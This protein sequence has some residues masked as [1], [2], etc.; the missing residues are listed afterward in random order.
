M[1]AIVFCFW[2]HLA[3]S[4]LRFLHFALIGMCGVVLGLLLLSCRYFAGL[5]FVFGSVQFVMNF[6]GC[7]C[8]RLPAEVGSS[9]WGVFVCSVL[10]LYCAVLPVASRFYGWPF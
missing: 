1:I 7:M 6:A 8:G 10:L 2:F 5:G 4:C 3:C 9:L